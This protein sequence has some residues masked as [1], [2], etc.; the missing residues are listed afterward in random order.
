M[1]IFYPAS[2][3]ILNI[4]GLFSLPIVRESLNRGCSG[5]VHLWTLIGTS[6]SHILLTI[7]SS[8]NFIIYCCMSSTFRA[9]FFRYAVGAIGLYYFQRL[10]KLISTAFSQKSYYYQPK[11]VSTQH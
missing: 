3:I 6:I 8:V 7:N 5:V 9:I 11:G 1:P 2:R 10:F 4:H